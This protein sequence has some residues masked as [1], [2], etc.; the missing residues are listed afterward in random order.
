MEF[1]LSELVVGIVFPQK[2]DSR[3]PNAT[4]LKVR[5]YFHIHKYTHTHTVYVC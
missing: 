4:L 2:L 3:E 5:I 1:I